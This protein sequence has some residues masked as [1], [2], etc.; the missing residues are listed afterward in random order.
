MPP[1]MQKQTK[2]TALMA[3]DIILKHKEHNLKNKLKQQKSL[4]LGAEQY[5][6]ED[7]IE[8]INMIKYESCCQRTYRKCAS[9]LN[10]SPFDD[11]MLEISLQ[12]NEN[13][14]AIFKLMMFLIK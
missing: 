8:V 4:L 12:N 3:P 11:Q 5:L 9:C 10:S 6:N 13:T 7:N 2:I 14:V 1:A